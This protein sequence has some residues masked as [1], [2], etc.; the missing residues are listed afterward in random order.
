MYYLEKQKTKSGKKSNMGYLNYS[1]DNVRTGLLNSI[2]KSNEAPLEGRE[3][4]FAVKNLTSTSNE[5]AIRSVKLL[6][7]ILS[8]ELS[9]YYNS[10][11][12]IA[13]GAITKNLTNQKT[14]KGTKLLFS[15]SF[16]SNYIVSDISKVIIE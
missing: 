11:Y 5:E 16:T 15:A 7:N 13:P 14:K 12:S 4:R 3:T 8:I 9:A 2:G 1:V 10:I 6:D